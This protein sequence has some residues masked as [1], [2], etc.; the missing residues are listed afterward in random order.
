MTAPDPVSPQPGGLFCPELLGQDQSWDD[1]PIQQEHDDL[2]EQMAGMFAS[3]SVL[4]V[5]HPL[6]QGQ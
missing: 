1:N 6:C 3:E 2:R 4:N 5:H